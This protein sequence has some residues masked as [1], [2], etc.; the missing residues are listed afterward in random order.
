MA[1]FTITKVL[2]ARPN[3]KIVFGFAIAVAL[4]VLLAAYPLTILGVVTVGIALYGF[5]QWCRERMEWWQLLV[6]LALAPTFVLN[7]GFD[8][9]AVGAGGFKFP[10]GDLLM[11]LALLLVTWRIGRTALQNILLD[12]P[13]ACLMALLL[14]TCCHLLI[15]VSRY[16]FYAV[17]DG[18]MFFESVIVILGVAWG[19]DQ[20]NTQLLKRWLFYIFLANLFYSYTFSWGDKIKSMSPSFGVFHPVALFG[21]YQQSALLLLLGAMYFVWIAPSAVRWPRW[22]LTLLSAAQLGGLA[23]LQARSMYVGIVL[24]LLVLF[25]F[26]ENRKLIGFASTVGWGVAVLLLFLVV[27]SALGITIQGRMGPVNLS[28]VGDQIKTV[29]AMGHA[30]TRMAHE[31]DRADWYGQVWD[32]VRSSPTNVVVG[33]GFGQALIN[34]EDEDGNPVRQPHNS[35]L[36]VLARLGFVGLSIWLLFIGLVLVRFVRFL[37]M[38][39]QSEGVTSTILWLF[40]C[41]LLFLEISSVQ[42]E[43]EFSHGTIPFYFLLGLGIGIMSIRKN[44]FDAGSMSAHALHTWPDLE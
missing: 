8:N 10:A 3:T 15:D 37:R 6:L 34:F 5:F 7:Y 14:M 30:N 18:S 26:H 40:L 20:R 2:D 11:F 22:L 25:L 16:G 4:G 17:R 13:V 43:L 28:F 31:D 9:L 1:T 19:Q 42:P 12:P 44:S 24:I 32:R 21:N 29:L 33:E 36:T 35:S 23:I 39:S 41:F 38:R 27:I